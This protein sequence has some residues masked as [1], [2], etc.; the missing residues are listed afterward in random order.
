MRPNILP[1]IAPRLRI[2]QAAHRSSVTRDSAFLE[3]T[4]SVSLGY[5]EGERVWELTWYRDKEQ[6]ID[7]ESNTLLG[8]VTLP[9][10]D[11]TD[12]ELRLGATDNDLAGSVAFAGVSVFVYLGSL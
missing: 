11:R 9:A 7:V 3:A 6:F 5:E 10:G 2:F 8:A 12:V 1:Q 4:V